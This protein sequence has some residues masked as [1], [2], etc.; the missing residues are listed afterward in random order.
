MQGK[1]TGS[2]S[3]KSHKKCPVLINYFIWSVYVHILQD[4]STCKI[5]DNEINE[6]HISFCAIYINKP[7]F[8]KNA[9]L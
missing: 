2:D 1:N 7:L 4:I 5:C 6:L 3:I 8:E 9:W